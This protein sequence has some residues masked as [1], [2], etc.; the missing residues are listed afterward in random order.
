M[1]M[2]VVPNGSLWTARYSGK[3]DLEGE[4]KQVKHCEFHVAHK[5]EVDSAAYLVTH[6]HFLTLDGL[7]EFITQLAICNNPIWGKI[8]SGDAIEYKLTS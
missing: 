7:K 6:I 1:P 8:F 4:P 2:V 3:G 5:I